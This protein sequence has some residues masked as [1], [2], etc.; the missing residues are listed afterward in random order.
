MKAGIGGRRALVS[1]DALDG[2][3][4]F[5]ELLV[6]IMVEPLLKRLL[7]FDCHRNPVLLKTA[8]LALPCPEAN[9]LPL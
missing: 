1:Q 4:P 9:F 6:A 5:V 2:E 8:A 7:E 3:R